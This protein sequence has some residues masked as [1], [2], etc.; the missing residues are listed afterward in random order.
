MGAEIYMLSI[1]GEK[2]QEF[3]EGF[4]KAKGYYPSWLRGKAY[5]ATM[6]WAEAIKKAGTT[7]TDKVIAAWEGLSYDGPAGTW[8]MRPCDHQAQVPYWVAE[9][10]KENKFYDHAYVGKATMVP[11]KDVEVSCEEAGCKR[12]AE[13]KK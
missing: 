5:T 13:Q 6:F 2:N 4:H 3:I 10:V 12:I 9:I 11:A 8:Y 1:P 7:D